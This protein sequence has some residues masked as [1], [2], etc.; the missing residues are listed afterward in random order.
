MPPPRADFGL[1]PFTAGS[2][3]DVQEVTGH[4][5]RHGDNG[6]VGAIADLE[7]PEFEELGRQIDIRVSR[8]IGAC[9]GRSRAVGPSIDALI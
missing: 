3:K 9:G 5:I 8:E 7:L 1:N 6:G 4:S 2:T